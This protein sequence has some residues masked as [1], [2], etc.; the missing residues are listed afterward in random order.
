MKKITLLGVALAT[1]VSVATVS[2]Q[3]DKITITEFT[4]TMENCNDENGKVM[5]DGNVL[6]WTDG[7]QIAVWGT[8]YQHGDV[9]HHVYFHRG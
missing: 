3:K 8:D 4:A 7:D 1:I 6:R 2:C 9:C 5:L